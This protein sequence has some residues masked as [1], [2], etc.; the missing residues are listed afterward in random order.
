MHVAY[1]IHARL[2]TDPIP[3]YSETCNRLDSVQLGE[4]LAQPVLRPKNREDMT[5][6]REIGSVGHQT[7]LGQTLI[8]GGLYGD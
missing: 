7:Y 4:R 5:K 2:T 8:E 6:R 3:P 1:Y